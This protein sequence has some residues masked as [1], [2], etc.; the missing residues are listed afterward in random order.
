M[1]APTRR[2]TRPPHLLNQP[3]RPSTHLRNR[4]EGRS[5]RQPRG[6]AI[7]S[8]TRTDV[9]QKSARNPYPTTIFAR[10]HK[11]GSRAPKA[12]ERTLDAGARTRPTTPTMEPAPPPAGPYLRPRRCDRAASTPPLDQLPRVLQKISQ[13]LGTTRR[14]VSMHVPK[15]GMDRLRLSC[16]RQQFRLPGLEGLLRIEIG[17]LRLCI[18]GAA[19][20]PPP[21]MEP[22][23]GD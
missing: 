2:E 10:G 23:D 14:K 4:E 21:P 13:P 19:P 20:P 17:G 1:P 22:N 8:N 16:Q 11:P 9:N 3:A 5:A 18:L 12:A 15:D 7:L 6:T